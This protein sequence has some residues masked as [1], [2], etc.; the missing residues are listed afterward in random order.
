M[1]TR[2]MNM[3]KKEFPQTW[4]VLPA[5]GVGSRMQADR[6][7]QYLDMTVK[8]VTKTVIEFTLDHLLAYSSGL[9]G[10]NLS[11]SGFHKVVV[12][13]TKGDPYWHCLLYTSDAADE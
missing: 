5:A 9:S 13:V 1:S 8:G 4:L 6:P 3:A 7:K 11:R 12:V 2:V 10:S